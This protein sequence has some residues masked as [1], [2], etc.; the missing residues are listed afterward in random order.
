MFCRALFLRVYLRLKRHPS[1]ICLL[2]AL[3][4]GGP[5]YESQFIRVCV[6]VYLVSF[7][8]FFFFS[9][10]MSVFRFDFAF[11]RSATS[12]SLIA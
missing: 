11:S 2:L 4:R 1:S 6:Q 10:R 9:L 8:F 12:P 5:S 3:R 7:F